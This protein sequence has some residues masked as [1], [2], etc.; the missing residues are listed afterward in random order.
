VVA[1]DPAREELTVKHDDIR[2]FMPGMIMPFKVRPGASVRDRKPGDMIRAT[3][4]V[5]DSTAYLMDVIVSGHAPLTDAAPAR[6]GVDRLEL[7]DAVP[8]TAFV[9]QT[10]T[11][12]R[13]STWRSRTVAVTFIYTRCPLPDFC[14]LM[15]R[16]FA[17]VQRGIVEDPALRDRV[18]L[19]SIS[20]DPAFD[21][22][23]VL[24]AHARR[25][26][27]DP[28][29]WSFLTGSREEIEPFAARFGV[30]IMQSDSESREIVHN[31]RTA[32]IDG[33]GRVASVMSGNDWTPADL[34]SVIKSTDAVR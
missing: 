33:E 22:P 16:H 5:E 27:A 17:A 11:A 15:D 13:L 28:A 6:K 1:V 20:V 26:G 12:R 9:D 31:L 7:G 19:L 18:Q 30:S 8:D 25:A 29:I 34:I 4:V 23:A 21:T 2:G 32:V 10:G 3:L 14:P 24:A